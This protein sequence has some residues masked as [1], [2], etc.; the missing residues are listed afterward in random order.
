MVRF[1]YRMHEKILKVVQVEFIFH[2]SFL[3][4]P[5]NHLNILHIF[6]SLK[7]TFYWK[8]EILYQNT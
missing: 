8:D 7:F 1:G 2:I 4:T 5:K 6:I 3:L